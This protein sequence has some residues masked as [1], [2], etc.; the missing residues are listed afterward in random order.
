MLVRDVPVEEH[1]IEG[2]R[3]A[4]MPDES[5]KRAHDRD[6]DANQHSGEHVVVERLGAVILQQARVVFSRDQLNSL[7][8]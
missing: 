2:D 1:T 4:V 8:Q 6:C 5:S 7:F 3:S